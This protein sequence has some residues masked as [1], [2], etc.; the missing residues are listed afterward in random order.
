MPAPMIAPIPSVIRFTGPRVRRSPPFS[1][2]APSRSSLIGFV[3]SSWLPIPDPPSRARAALARALAPE[4]A[5][6][7]SP[8]SGSRAP[9]WPLTVDF[10]KPCRQVPDIRGRAPPD[11][12]RRRCPAPRPANPPRHAKPLQPAPGVM[13][14]MATSGLR[15]QR[16][17]AAQPF[18]SHRRIG[19]CLGCGGENRAK[20]DIIGRSGIGLAH[21][22]E[23]RA[24]RTQPSYPAQR[25]LA[26]P[27]PANRPGPRAPRPRP[28]SPRYRAG[29]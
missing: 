4:I 24:S 6:H 20:S 2:F 14:P 21:L 23:R 25:S 22:I 19:A 28:Q 18:D 16:P 26:P 3:A 11:P 29:R 13:P 1:P 15:V 12:L 10:G 27:T 5:G 9:A 8:P 7:R 17:G